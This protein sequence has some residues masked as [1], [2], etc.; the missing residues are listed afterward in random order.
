VHASPNG[1]VMENF[2]RGF[3]V[4]FIEFAQRRRREDPT[5]GMGRRPSSRTTAWSALRSSC[6]EPSGTPIHLRLMAAAR[7]MLPRGRRASRVFDVLGLE[8]AGASEGQKLRGRMGAA[9]QSTAY[10][11][12]PAVSGKNAQKRQRGDPARTSLT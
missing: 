7:E 1:W 6:F 3:R 10:S 8:L 2:H 11:V 9:G 4:R 5:A 12:C